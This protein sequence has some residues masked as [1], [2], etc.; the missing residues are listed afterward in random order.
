MISKNLQIFSLQP[1]LYNFAFSLKF[2]KFF[3]ITRTI[4]S[5]GRSKQFWLLNTISSY[6]ENYCLQCQSVWFIEY[7][8][9]YIG[10]RFSIFFSKFLIFFKFVSVLKHGATKMSLNIASVYI[11]ENWT[12]STQGIHF[13]KHSWQ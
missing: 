9:K 7:V 6:L 13:K 8:L 3:L 11:Q 5:H 4:F 12:K 2:Q 1:K 10:N